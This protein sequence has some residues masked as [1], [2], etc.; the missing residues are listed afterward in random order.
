M[1][2]LA[3]LAAVAPAR[4]PVEALEQ[5][6]PTTPCRTLGQQLSGTLN[7]P[8]RGRVAHRYPPWDRSWRAA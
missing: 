7:Q 8:E 5:G 2:E 3:K 6:T 4:L 1:R